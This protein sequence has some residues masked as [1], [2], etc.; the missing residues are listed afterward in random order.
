MQPFCR[1]HLAQGSMQRSSMSIMRPHVGLRSGCAR[2]GVIVAAAPPPNILTL[3]FAE[4]KEVRSRLSASV[5]ASESHFDCQ[6][7]DF[8]VFDGA[9]P[10]LTGPHNGGRMRLE[11]GEIGRQANASIM[12]TSGDTVMMVTACAD[13]GATGDG[14][15][16]PLSVNYN[17]RLSSAGLTAGGFVKRDGRASEAE[18]LT[19]RLVDRPIRPMFN[20][21]W[22]CETQV[23]EMVM[24]FDES[25]LPE[26]LAITAAAA[27][28]LISDIPFEKAVAG[29]RVGLIKSEAVGGEE[30][31]VVNPTAQEMSRSRLDLLMAGTKDAVLMIEGFC[32]FLTDE[33]MLVAIEMG[34]ASISTMCTQMEGWAKE[35][36]K[37]KKFGSLVSLP[38][39]L[40][41]KV[42]KLIGVQLTAD[43][44]SKAEGAARHK[45]EEALLGRN[46]ID[47]PSHQPDEILPTPLELSVAFKKVASSAL[48]KTVASSALR[49]VVLKTGKR[50]DG[51]STTDIRPIN[52]RAGVLPRT[53]GSSLF[54]RGETQALCV[55]TLG[56]SSNS[57]RKGGVQAAAL[58]VATLG[59]SSNSQ[60]QGGVQ[61]AALCVAT[62]GSSTNSQ[63]KGGVQAAVPNGSK[64]SNFYLHYFFPPSSVG[65]TG[66]VGMAGRRELGH[67]CLAQRALEP[68]LPDNETFPY[69]VRIESNI[70]ESNGS[71]SMASVC[72]GCLALMD[73]GVPI[74][75]PVA[76]IAMGLILEPDGRFQVLS[77]ILGTE[78]ALGDMDF[79]VEGITIDIMRQALS[80]A[81]EPNL[82][83]PGPRNS[84]C[85]LPAP[86]T[87]DVEKRSTVVGMGGKTIRAILDQS[88]ATSLTINDEGVLEVLA[89]SQTAIDAALEFIKL[90]ID[91]PPPGKIFNQTAIDAALEFIK[92]LIDDPPPGKIFKSRIVTQTQAFGAFVELG[93]DCIGLVHLSELDVGNV[94]EVARVVSIGD[95]VDVM[96]LP[97]V[98]GGKI[99]LSMRAAKLHAAGEWDSKA[100]KQA[101]DGGQTAG[102][103]L[104]AR[105]VG[106]GRGGA[107]GRGQDMD[108]GRGGGRGRSG[109]D[110]P[111]IRRP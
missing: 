62:L 65:E 47:D 9:V 32:D 13:S 99:R 56:S 61:A 23:L 36:G 83:Y 24:S 100:M 70:T 37:K 35:V 4:G 22:A 29:V 107:G 10:R 40:E 108:G 66:R 3:K 98:P 59:S 57:Q 31:F 90:L 48:R 94:A 95:K 38:K 79:K 85:P 12:A 69:V 96:V 77:D 21:G 19:S 78:D 64:E 1:M 97:S 30:K 81:M 93:P 104:S 92:L 103:Q 67:G 7:G 52:S 6:P 75:R 58:C 80:Q 89:P 26:P 88:G 106:R 20:K 45:V 49:K 55:A 11:T 27:S 53:H 82:I 73:A 84:A 87:V 54:T 71:S 101:G 2:R 109:E 102:Q 110:R 42:E 5:F 14:S 91:D 33:Q 28:L 17:E 34:Q 46:L 25:T 15:F 39:G 76:G 63:R 44:R 51:R 72:G 86:L 60:Q 43:V 74:K 50:I 68:I 111:P 8:D 18:T 16:V 105:V 41:E